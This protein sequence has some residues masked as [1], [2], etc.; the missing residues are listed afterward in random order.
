M[1]CSNCGHKLEK[2]WRHCPI[3][4][5]V[6]GSE[7]GDAFSGIFKDLDKMTKEMGF[8]FDTDMEV[9]DLSQMFNEIMKNM[10]SPQRKGFS[11]RI[12]QRNNEAPKVSF[13]RF[14]GRDEATPVEKKRHIMPKLRKPIDGKPMGHK[15]GIKLPGETEEPKTE[16]RRSGNRVIVDI[17]LP[18]V[19]NQSYIDVDELENSIEVKAVAGGRGYFKIIKK[20]EFSKIVKKTFDDGV[21]HMELL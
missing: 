17:I 21:L 20:P 19:K 12:N 14:G 15:I 10:N 4:G 18:G 3:C 1:N 13:R 6:A 11:I 2:G 8:K 5:A 9:I 16:I 7:K